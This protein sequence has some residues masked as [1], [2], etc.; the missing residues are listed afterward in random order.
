MNWVGFSPNT[1]NPIAEGTPIRRYVFGALS[2]GSISIQG[3]SHVSPGISTNDL[4]RLP[5]KASMFE[6]TFGMTEAEFLTLPNLSNST[7]SPSIV[8]G[9]TYV[10]GDWNGT[11]ICGKGI[12]VVNGDARINTTCAGGF[13]GLLYV[14]GQYNMQ[15]NASIQGAI[16]VE[17]HVETRLRGTGN[18]KVEY[19]PM[20]LLEVGKSLSPWN[21]KQVAGSWRL[22]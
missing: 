14:K 15:G 16:V 1:S 20:V 3:A 21:F 17:G 9:L 2:A 7:S 22:R 13:Q 4:L 6:T 10:N 12:V 11:S 5:S 18:D 19:D 8:N